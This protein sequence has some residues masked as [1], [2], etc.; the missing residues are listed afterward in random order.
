MPFDFK[1]FSIS[2]K[3]IKAKRQIKAKKQIKIKQIE[4]INS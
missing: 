2:K 1:I 3:Q 4:P